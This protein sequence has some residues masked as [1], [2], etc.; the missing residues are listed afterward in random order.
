M[1]NVNF[2]ITN[3]QQMY[4]TIIVDILDINHYICL[5]TVS[6]R[7]QSFNSFFPGTKELTCILLKQLYC[8]VAR[9][10]TSMIL[11]ARRDPVLLRLLV[12]H[13]VGVA[14]CLKKQGNFYYNLVNFLSKFPLKAHWK[15]LAHLDL[16]CF[17]AIV[18]QNTI[19]KTNNCP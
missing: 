4:L 10:D 8:W 19:C 13:V 14:V 12:N 15:A 2:S 3:S 9:N 6:V 17:N 1:N 5:R 18:P 7:L 11:L 16:F